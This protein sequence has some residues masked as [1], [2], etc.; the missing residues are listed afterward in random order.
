MQTRKRKGINYKEVE[1]SNSSDYI[2]IETISDIPSDTS[3]WENE[4]IKALNIEIKNIESVNSSFL[5]QGDANNENIVEDRFKI[6]E[7]KDFDRNKINNINSNELKLLDGSVASLIMKIKYIINLSDGP[8]KK[9]VRVDG[10]VMSLLNMLGFDK[11]PYIMYPQYEYSAL[12]KNSKITSKVEFIVINSGKYVLLIV[13]DKHK[14]NTGYFN[15]WSENQI[16]GEMFGCVYHTIQLIEYNS[17]KIVFPIK[18]SAVRIIGT[19]FTFYHSEVSKQ[20]TEECYKK[21]PTKNSMTIYRYP[22]IY[23]EDE[24]TIAPIKALDFCNPKDRLIILQTFK[25]IQLFDKKKNS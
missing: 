23:D 17:E 18:V 12:F 8:A 21:L 20:Y 25:S 1:T 11:Y 7:L 14:D 13:E 22:S 10:F 4:H 15:N 5:S 16:A 2:I 24:N 6:L 19:M 9:E 3:S